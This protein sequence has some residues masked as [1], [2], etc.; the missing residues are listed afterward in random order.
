MLKSICGIS[1]CLFVTVSQ[2]Q[3]RAAPP[4][5]DVVF[6]TVDSQQLKLDLYL[7]EKVEHPPLVV[8]IHGGGWRAGSAQGP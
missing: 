7:P 5:K 3:V 1:L 4:T 2:H 8:F 6:A